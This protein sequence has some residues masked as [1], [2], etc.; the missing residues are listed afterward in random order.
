M[1]RVTRHPVLTARPV[2]MAFDLLLGG[3]FLTLRGA[4]FR[5]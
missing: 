3:S 1:A 2:R 4:S 5:S